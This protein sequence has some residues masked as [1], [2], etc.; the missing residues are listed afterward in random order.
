LSLAEDAQRVATHLHDA[1]L[2]RNRETPLRSGMYPPHEIIIRD[3]VFSSGDLRQKQLMLALVNRAMTETD[4]ETERDQL[5]WLAEGAIY[6]RFDMKDEELIL[7][8]NDL[9]ALNQKFP[10]VKEALA[11]VVRRIRRGSE[12]ER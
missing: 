12:M 10:L 9:A 3:E 1:I 2:F 6:A 11:A 8:T 5:P 4:I 7:T